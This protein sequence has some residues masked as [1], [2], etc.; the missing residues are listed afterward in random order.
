MIDEYIA[1]LVGVGLDKKL[2]EPEDK[3]YT[4][5]Q[6]LEIFKLDDYEEP[7]RPAGEMDLEEILTKLTDEAYDRYIIEQ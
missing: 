5:N 3:I 6:Y 2:I 1:K 7:K 4:I